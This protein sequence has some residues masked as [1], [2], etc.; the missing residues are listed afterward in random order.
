V[1]DGTVG[2]VREA[3]EHSLGKSKLCASNELLIP[4]SRVVKILHKRS[5]C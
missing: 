2:V 4:Q 5:A 3:F 1:S